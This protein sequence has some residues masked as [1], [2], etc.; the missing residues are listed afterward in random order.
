M[1]VLD[2][3]GDRPKGRGSF[4]VNL[5]R[6]IITNGD[7]VASLRESAYNDRAVVWQSEWGGL[8]HSCVRWKSTC[9]NGKGLFLAWLSAFLEIS[10][11]FI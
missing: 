9:L 1:G 7:F 5:P 6:P 8:R 11:P 3:G 2:F 4:G 10:A